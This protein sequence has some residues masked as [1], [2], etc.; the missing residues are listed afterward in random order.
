[1]NTAITDN[2]KILYPPGG[3]LLWIIIFIELI[4]F[5]AGLISMV[6][7]SNQEP[8]SFHVSRSLL[9]ATIGMV[10]TILLLT[11]GFFMASSVKELKANNQKRTKLYLLLTIFFGLMFLVLKSIE[12]SQKISSGLT[13][14]YNTFFNFYWMLTMFHFLHVLVGMVILISL[15]LG[16]KKE[17]S[18]IT[19]GDFESGAAFWHMCDL[20]WLLIFPIIY[21]IP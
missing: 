14:G 1:M 16:I 7:F 3:I 11:S 12:Y 8:E 2:K 6:Y 9:N 4:T 19:I 17:P 15:N 21:L 5:G 10:N 13:F 20:I 18:K